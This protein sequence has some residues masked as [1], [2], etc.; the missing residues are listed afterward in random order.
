[1]EQVE[2]EILA[3]VITATHGTLQQ[4]AILRTDAAFAK[5]LVHDCGAAK[6][7]KAKAAPAEVTPA[8]PS[9]SKKQ[10][11][12]KEPVLKAPPAAAPPAD[13]ATMANADK[14]DPPVQTSAPNPA[15]TS[16]DAPA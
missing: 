16:M 10:S 14:A 4:G 7:V 3:Q 5:H 6:Y 8:K 15:G 12:P 2:V 1:M 13:P 9:P 11:A